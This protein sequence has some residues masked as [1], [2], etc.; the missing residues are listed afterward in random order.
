MLRKQ[1]IFI[2]ILGMFLISLSSAIT[3]VSFI[4]D[5]Q[6]KIEKGAELTNYGKIEIYEKAWYDIFN[7]FGTRKKVKEIELKENTEKCGASCFAEGE[8]ILYKDGVLVE[9]VLWKRSFD[10]MQTWVDWNSFVNWRI[11]V[12][13]KNRYQ[14]VPKYG[15]GKCIEKYDEKNGTKYEECEQTEVG[16][17]IIDTGEWVS[18]ELGKVYPAGSYRWRLEGSKK[19]T[20]VLDWQLKTNGKIIKEWAIWGIIGQGGATAQVNLTS[21]ANNSI[22]YINPV[23]LSSFANITASEVYLANATLFDNSTGSWG[24]RETTNIPPVGLISYYTFDELSGNLIDIISGYNLTANSGVT[25]GQS[26]SDAKI[27]YSWYFDGSNVNVMRD[28]GDEINLS[29]YS[30]NLWIKPNSCSGGRSVFLYKGYGSYDALQL[31]IA[32]GKISLFT[33][34]YGSGGKEHIFGSCIAGLYNMYTMFVNTSSVRLWVNG[35][36]VL[37]DTPFPDVDLTKRYFAI[38]YNYD[39]P[40]NPDFLGYLDEFSIWNK[41]LTQNEILQLYNSGN[42]K[43]NIVNRQ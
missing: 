41:S 20:T 4:E 36:S 28:F 13:N 30:Y 3:E 26:G 35:V 32:D 38:G 27:N 29:G 15:E 21:P 31:I 18:L 8:I 10:N 14:E 5:V 39:Y 6:K 33:Y 23:S 34:A 1:F 11:L 17:D 12:E 19:P 9:D 2:F 16:T 22:V 43:R 25:R 7:W 37:N 42:G 40:N 24:E